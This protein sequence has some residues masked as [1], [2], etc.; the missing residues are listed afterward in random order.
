MERP[1][2]AT[3]ALQIEKVKE[4]LKRLI[5]AYKDQEEK[6]AV[7]SK[8]SPQVKKFLNNVR[9][10]RKHFEHELNINL[11]RAENFNTSIDLYFA[12]AEKIAKK[13]KKELEKKRTKLEKLTKLFKRI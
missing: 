12:K 10:L 13:K 1:S 5:K 7:I 4:E 8:K 9:A 2:A 6:L 11:I 3:V